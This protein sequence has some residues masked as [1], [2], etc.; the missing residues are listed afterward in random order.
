MPGNYQKQGYLRNFWWQN[1]FLPHFPVLGK[2]SILPVHLHETHTTDRWTD[3]S[4]IYRSNL[5]CRCGRSKKGKARWIFIQNGVVYVCPHKPTSCALQQPARL[6]PTVFFL[7]RGR[8]VPNAC[9]NPMWL[10]MER[11][12]LWK[13]AS[14]CNWRGTCL[15]VTAALPPLNP[16]SL[17]K[18]PINSIFGCL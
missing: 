1:L 9:P 15:R 17:R 16:I 10:L 14:R 7:L 4:S 5:L 18:G 2:N 11:K 3:Q 6:I 8:A 13:V 12:G